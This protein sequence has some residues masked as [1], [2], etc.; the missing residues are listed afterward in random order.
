MPP[1]F[2]PTRER[3]HRRLAKQAS[4]AGEDGAHAKTTAGQDSNALTV[5]PASKEEREERRRKMREELRAQQVAPKISAKKQK[6]LDKYIV[7]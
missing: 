6:R 5:V 4:S 2:A 3:K 7:C 1:K